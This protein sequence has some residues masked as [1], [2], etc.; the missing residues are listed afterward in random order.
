VI[1]KARFSTIAI[2]IVALL[3]SVSLTIG[4]AQNNPDK[5]SELVSNQNEA[6]LGIGIPDSKSGLGSELGLSTRAKTFWCITILLAGYG[7]WLSNRTKRSGKSGSQEMEITSKL[8]LT[9]RTSLML[10][11]VKNRS[12]LCAVGPEQVTI[13]PHD[14]NSSLPFHDL[15]V[16]EGAHSLASE[17]DDAA[18]PNEENQIRS[19]G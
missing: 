16:D 3:G 12:V 1:K 13:V 10:V 4:Y 18:A 7:A 14:M 2:A 15:L 17:G 11:K 6:P 8:M 19:I 5:N 9:P